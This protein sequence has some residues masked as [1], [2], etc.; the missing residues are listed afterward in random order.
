[1]DKSFD[2]Q[3]V[4][5]ALNFLFGKKD[6]HLLV[7]ALIDLRTNFFAWNAMAE[8]LKCFPLCARVKVDRP[9]LADT[10]RTSASPLM[11]RPNASKLFERIWRPKSHSRCYAVMRQPQKDHLLGGHFSRLS[12]L[13]VTPFQAKSWPVYFPQ[14][15]GI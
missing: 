1:M 3:V 12:A 11:R 15:V 2:F 4:Y 6:R 8:V 14:Y 9:R 10:S 7:A 5:A 13:G